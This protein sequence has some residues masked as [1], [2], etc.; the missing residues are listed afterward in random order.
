M[1]NG[2]ERIG[3]Y[4]GTFAPVHNGHVAAARAF[5]EQMKLDRLLIVP[6]Y[7]TP[8][9]DMDASDDP[10][11]RMKM[12]K[13]AFGDDD[14]IE[15]SD[16]EIKRGGKSYTI[17][18][19]KALTKSDRKLFLMCGTDMMLSFDK[20]RDFESIFKLC[21][22]VYVRRENDASL[23]PRIIAKNQEYY[24]K[25]GVAFRKIIVDPIDINSTDIRGLVKSGQDISDLVPAGVAD[26][27]QKYG[28][29]NA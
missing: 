28:L 10:E 26:Y 21:C 11:H 22:P 23:D 4:G 18:T 19:I 5:L 29:Y 6:T 2:I 7:I 16:I 3:V 17:D 27:I 12:C 24:E 13:L 8:H 14:C 1:I 9:K 25:Y 20:W 15:V